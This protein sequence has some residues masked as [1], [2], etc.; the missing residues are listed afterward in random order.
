MNPAALFSNKHLSVTYNQLSMF[1]TLETQIK[2]G[3]INNI[4]ILFIKFVKDVFYISFCVC[5][6]T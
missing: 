2:E 3:K 5:V 6:C 4:F 1:Y